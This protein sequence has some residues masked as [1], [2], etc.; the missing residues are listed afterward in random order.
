MRS[1]QLSRKTSV[2]TFSLYCQQQ[3]FDAKRRLIQRVFQVQRKE[4]IPALELCP[5]SVDLNSFPSTQQNQFA[6]FVICFLSTAQSLQMDCVCGGEGERHPERLM[7]YEMISS[8]AV[9]PLLRVHTGW[10]LF[11]A[12]SWLRFCCYDCDCCCGVYVCVC[13][14][15]D[16]HCNCLLLV[17]CSILLSVTSIRART[18]TFYLVHLNNASDGE[19]WAHFLKLSVQVPVA[20]SLCV[21]MLPQMLPLGWSARQIGRCSPYRQLLFYCIHSLLMYL[22]L[23]DHHHHQHS[24]FRRSLPALHSVWLSFNCPFVCFCRFLLPLL[25]FSSS[26]LATFHCAFPLVLF[27]SCCCCPTNTGLHLPVNL[28]LWFECLTQSYQCFLSLDICTTLP[29]FCLTTTTTTDCHVDP[30]CWLHF[31]QWRMAIA[32]DRLFK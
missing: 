1:L 4:K 8:F 2:F 3:W 24:Y 19:C 30:R 22:S 29:Y 27:A 20:C 12:I 16:C 15:S 13:T 23:S 17:L 6:P 10:H 7:I 18:H 26:V 28:R 32:V 5:L 14:T 11:I 25:S 31:S 21:W 9:W